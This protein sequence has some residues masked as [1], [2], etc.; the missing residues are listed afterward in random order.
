MFSQRP[1]H[2]NVLEEARLLQK[3]RFINQLDVDDPM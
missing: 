3:I 1:M 2:A